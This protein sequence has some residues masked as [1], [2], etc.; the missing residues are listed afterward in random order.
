[1]SLSDCAKCWDTPCECGNEGYLVLYL[2]EGR[3]HT[4]SREEF[5]KLKEHL[6]AEMK[7]WLKEK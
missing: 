2:P 6:K 3:D 7:K 5:N 1:M 4:L